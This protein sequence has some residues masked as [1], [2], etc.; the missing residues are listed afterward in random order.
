VVHHRL[1][2]GQQPAGGVLGDPQRRGQLQPDAAFDHLGQHPAIDC[3]I[4]QRLPP[5]HVHSL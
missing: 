3:R 5:H 1:G 2:E 4:P